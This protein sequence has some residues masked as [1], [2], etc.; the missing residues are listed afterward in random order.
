MGPILLSMI[1]GIAAASA[2]TVFNRAGE[3]AKN[4]P[5]AS[6]GDSRGSRPAS[7]E[8]NAIM[9]IYDDESETGAD[10][11]YIS[12][13]EESETG[14]AKAKPRATAKGGKPA[15]RRTAFLP[16]TPIATTATANVA[17]GP[18]LNCAFK[19]IGMQLFGTNQNL[20]LFNGATIRGKP[21]EASAGSIGG[22]AFGTTDIT[23]F[24]EWD[25]A[26][27]GETFNLSFTNTHTATVTPTGWLI[28]YA[29]P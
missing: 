22:A 1:G 4:S 10:E 25:T 28:G 19:A 26:N 2:A 16:S 17:M 12:G 13:E 24:F 5:G 6:P 27:P 7:N 9:G 11:I 14:A 29:A 20:L 18:A 3:R 21:Q 23:F 15:F 8:R